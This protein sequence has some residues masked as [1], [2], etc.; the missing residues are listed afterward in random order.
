MYNGQPAYVS[1]LSCFA[2]PSAEKVIGSCL[3]Y[4]ADHCN[5]DEMKTILGMETKVTSDLMCFTFFPLP[6]LR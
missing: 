3:T 1:Q 6:F 5:S 2:I 4:T